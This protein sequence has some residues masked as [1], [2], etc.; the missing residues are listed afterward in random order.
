MLL[1]KN[2]YMIDPKSRR[3]GTFDILIKDDKIIKIDSSIT[4]F[5]LSANERNNLE[6]INAD[7]MMIIPGLVDVHVHFRDP[8][9][10]YKEDIYTGAKAAAKGGY[11]TVVLMANTKPTVDNN[12]TLQYVINKGKET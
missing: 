10:T 2:G 8:G 7:N 3:E 9:F 12:E 5:D 4:E 1:I 11:T 6:I